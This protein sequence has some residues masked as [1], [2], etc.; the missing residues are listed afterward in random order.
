MRPTVEAWSPNHWTTRKRA[1][2]SIFNR[3]SAPQG[4]L[5]LS[6]SGLVTHL[7]DSQNP[8]PATLAALL[9]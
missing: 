6:L 8:V 3:S 5:S 1:H 4:S 2:F 7:S 9:V